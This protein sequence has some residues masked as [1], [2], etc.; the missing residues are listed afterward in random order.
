MRWQNPWAWVGLLTLVL[1][2]LVHLFSRRPARV[3]PFPSL[4]FLDVS[5]LLPTRRTRLSD[6][7]L[8]LVRLAI[9]IVAV[10]ALAQPLWRANAGASASQVAR[11]IVVDTHPSAG[12]PGASAALERAYASLAGEP[13]ASLRIAT[14][15]PHAVL[16]G[17]VAW[18]YT[19]P[20][21]AELVV[22]SDFRREA[23]DSLDLAALPADT[24]LRL[25]R[26]P[27]VTRGAPT[28]RAMPSHRTIVRWAFGA[29]PEVSNAV[30]TSV[31]R[32]GGIALEDTAT[33]APTDSTARTI[34]VASPT[35][36]SGVAWARTARPLSA[37]WMGD[38]VYALRADSALVTSAE[39]IALTD[40]SISAP[41][42]VI[43]R[44][45]NHA[46]VVAAAAIAGANGAARLLLWSRAPDDAIVTAALLLSASTD[47]ATVTSRQTVTSRP[48]VN[49]ANDDQLRR[50]ERAPAASARVA[51]ARARG[52]YDSGPSDGRFLWLVVL[53]LLAAETL[54]RQRQSR[55][56]ATSIG[57]GSD[58]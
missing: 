3:E 42:V 55:V 8:L 51:Y 54:L 20:G 53:A 13:G 49:G 19:Q 39:L 14:S 35:A 24:R 1:P 5:R 28:S 37:R 44:A 18:L 6:L 11:A 32:L 27:S 47:R 43:V 50:W 48:T 41:F 56:V 36:D 29:T 33:T 9:L 31:R 52:D 57:R 4:R 15:A 45:A 23:I 2:I 10:A 17:A 26:V 12:D 34:V 58:G 7:P 30:R 16:E 46:P 40:T 22:L 25:V 21:S 38:A